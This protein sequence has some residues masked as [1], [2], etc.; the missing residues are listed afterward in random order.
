MY[1]CKCKIYPGQPLPSYHCFFAIEIFKIYYKTSSCFGD[2]YN[3]EL[4]IFGKCKTL[5][6]QCT[7]V[8]LPLFLHIN[9][10]DITLE[11][12]M[13]H[14]CVKHSVFLSSR[15]CLT[16]LYKCSGLCRFGHVLNSLYI[17]SHCSSITDTCSYLY[18]KIGRYHIL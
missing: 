13:G 11:Q 16:S 3:P 4:M 5:A 14:L 1:L 18:I 17:A 9:Y 15:S 7:T 2:G 10:T 6:N 8:A 12:I